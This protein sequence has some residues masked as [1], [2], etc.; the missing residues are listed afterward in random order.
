M[1]RNLDDVILEVD[2]LEVEQVNQKEIADA[3]GIDVEQVRGRDDDDYNLDMDDG[4]EL[5]FG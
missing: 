1:V 2:E 5:D 4:Q 3:L